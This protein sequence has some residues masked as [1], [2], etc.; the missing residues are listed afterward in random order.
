M[1]II[2]KVKS[3]IG[4]GHER[5]V[6][7]KKN[8]LL[9]VLFKGV[10]ILVGFAVSPL[11]VAYLDPTRLGVFILIS[12]MMDWFADFDMGIGNGLKN[13]FGAAV[14]N[15]NEEEARS[16]VSTAYGALSAIAGALALVFVF[17]S[18]VIPWS[19][20]TDTDPS[21]NSEIQLLA[22][23]IFAAFAVRFVSSLI[24]IIFNSLQETAKVD[25]FNLLSKIVFLVLIVLLFYFTESSLILFGTAKS[26]TFAF[27]PI[28]IGIWAFRGELKRY[29]PSFSTMKRGHLKALLSIGAMY[30]LIRIAMLVIY[31]TNTFLIAT[32]LDIELVPVYDFPFKYFS[33]LSMF[34]MIVTNQLWGAYIEAYEKGDFE[35]ISKIVGNLMK[36]WM[37]TVALGMIMILF[38]DTFYY[39]WI[40]VWQEQDKVM[41]FPKSVSVFICI[42]V[43]FSNFINV[44]NLVLNGTGKIRLQTIGVIAAAILNIPLSIFFVEVMDMGLNG[45]I[46]GTIVSLIP[47]AIFSPIQVRK[48]LAQ[49][50]TGI[51]SK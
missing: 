23:I 9:A 42:S 36:A 26:F 27:V 33:I 51:W 22:I 47:N 5:S 31:E 21:M 17:A 46:L 35:W 39:Y 45:I 6:K 34:F 44:F 13:K 40:N 7:A 16:Y 4:D 8:I 3:L 37:G 30:F 50:D 18:F 20:V 25:F 48:I 38:S 14:A 19:K 1:N 41:V 2:K 29:A 24:Y 49:K 10:G 28:I 11:S 15:G 12:G 43:C 32:L